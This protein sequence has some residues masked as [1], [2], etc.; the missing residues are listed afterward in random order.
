MKNTNGR[1]DV[2]NADDLVIDREDV[3]AD[4]SLRFGMDVVGDPPPWV[5]CAAWVDMYSSS[6]TSGVYFR[7]LQIRDEIGDVLARQSVGGCVG[8]R[9]DAAGIP[10]LQDFRDVVGRGRIA[11]DQIRMRRI[12]QHAFEPRADDALIERSDRVAR[13]ALLLEE[14]LTGRRRAAGQRDCRAAGRRQ[15]VADVRVLD[16]HR[17]VPAVERCVVFDDQHLFVH[18]AVKHAAELRADDLIA[19]RS[20]RGVKRIDVTSPGT[21]SF[22]RRI[23]GTQNE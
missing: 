18:L 10:A 8:H 20:D 21:V 14:R 5:S 7:G 17:V 3:P 19:V 15:R 23:A 1:D 11:V 6:A 9:A 13:R 16:L 22:L 12:V 4:E 2:L